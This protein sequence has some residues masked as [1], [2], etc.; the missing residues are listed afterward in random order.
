MVHSNS[1]GA[2]GILGVKKSVDGV[3]LY[4]A[5]NTD[6]FVGLR[7]RYVIFLADAMTLGNSIYGL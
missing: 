4:F 5:H 7:L 3:W 2:V 1:T 6:T